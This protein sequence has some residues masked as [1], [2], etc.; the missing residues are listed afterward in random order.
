MT[1]SYPVQTAEDAYDAC[2]P[3]DALQ[4]NDPRYVDLT[5]ARGGESLAQHVASRIRR[6]KSPHFHQQLITGHR[7]CGKSTEL[8]QLSARLEQEQFLTVYLNVEDVLDLGDVCYQDVL[9]GIAKAVEEKLRKNDI[10]I[11]DALIQELEKWF[12]EKILTEE[13]RQDI[14]GTLKADFGIEMKVPLFAR[15]LAAFTGE[16]HH[17]SSRRVQIR[18]VIEQELSVFMLRLNTLLGEARKRVRERGKKDIVVLVDGLEKMLYREL[19]NGQSSHSA[20]FVQHAEQLK[21]PQCHIIYTAPIWL[22]FTTN[23]GDDFSDPTFVIPMVNYTSKEGKRCLFDVIERRIEVEK[24]FASEETVYKLIGMSGGSVRDLMRLVRMSC[25]TA[26]EKITP[27]NGERAIRALV[28]EYDRLLR[29]KDIP[30]LLSVAEHRRVPGNEASADLLR[31]RLVHEY[32]NDERRADVHPALRLTPRL[33][34][35]L[36]S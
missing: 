21:A 17:G 7:G 22:V 3:E 2:Y 28:R 9:L 23:L 32:Q 27:E 36:G 6:T 31:H 4:P 15:M 24:V 34:E 19:R 20:L 10:K 25:E 13:Q 11:N 30:N 5:A 1:T 35:K 14:D 18:Q 26:E 12:A 8:L 33:R 16:I 29:D